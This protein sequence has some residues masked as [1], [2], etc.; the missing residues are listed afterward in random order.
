VK[1]KIISGGQTGADL[2]GLWVA[3]CF[4]LE[5]GGHAPKDFKT[6]IGP[7]LELAQV[8]DLIEHSHG[9]RERTIENIKNSH[10][11]LI[12]GRLLQERGTQLT[13]N[14]ATKLSKPLYIIEDIRPQFGFLDYFWG[15]GMRDRPQDYQT[16]RAAVSYVANLSH[17]QTIGGVTFPGRDHVIINIAG[18]SSNG[19]SNAESFAFAFMG[20]W[21]FLIELH[22]QLGRAGEIKHLPADL[23]WNLL[24]FLKDEYSPE[25]AVELDSFIKSQKL[26]VMVDQK[27][28]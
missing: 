24:H 20:F 26:E 6:S 27:S 2:A 19:P 5:T 22:R 1:I 10:V 25:R 14:V 17:S 15:Q 12:F 3:R 23:S 8:F 16:M 9:Y 18:N 28:I 21:Q 7:R 4:G 13:A 11:T